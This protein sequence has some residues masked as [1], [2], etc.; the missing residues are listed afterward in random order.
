MPDDLVPD[1]P[2]PDDPAPD[3]PAPDAETPPP[4]GFDPAGYWEDRLR[5]RGD[6]RGTGQQSFDLRYNRWLYRRQTDV[7]GQVVASL[8]VDPR[9]LRILDVGSGTGAFIDF[10]EAYRP[11]G[12]VGCDF[13]DTAVSLLRRRF[14]SRRFHR[15]DVTQPPPD[16]GG[17]FDLITVMSVLFHVVDEE[18]FA[19]ALDH[20][21]SLLAPGGTLLLNDV[22]G[23]R[24]ARTHPHV[25]FR[26]WEDYRPHLERHGVLAE[27]TV[28]LFFT[29]NRHLVPRLGPRLL[30]VLRAGRLLYALDTLLAR[31]GL[32]GGRGQRLLVARRRQR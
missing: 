9:E 6:L 25:R 27:R 14:P 21:C 13:T 7:V 19:S 8:D 20:L 32:S 1:D 17:P 30:S 22:L 10:F 26:S 12:L 28:P 3:D 15:W 11:A 24:P 29:L 5:K 2:V 31:T 16:L 4:A 18:R 23:S